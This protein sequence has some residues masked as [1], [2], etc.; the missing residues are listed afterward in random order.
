MK[1]DKIG[2][3]PDDKALA[4]LRRISEIVKEYTTKKNALEAEVRAFMD[5]VGH[6]KSL[7]AIGHTTSHC[8]SVFDREP[9]VTVDHL[10][11]CLL[12]SAWRHVYDGLNIA[13]IATAKDK[14][15]LDIFLSNPCEFT[16][17]NIREK[18][19]DYLLDT[20]QHVLRGLAECFSSL[21]AVYRSH[22]R[23]KIGVEG[24]PKRMIVQYAFDS[25]GWARYGGDQVKD[26]I[27][28]VQSLRGEPRFGY[29]EFDVLSRE[30]KRHG[31][32]DWPGG[33]LKAFK[34]GNAHIVFNKDTLK[35]VNLAL[36]EYYGDVIAD[37]PEDKPAKKRESREVSADLAYYPTPAPVAETIVDL[38]RPKSGDVILE[39]SCGDGRLMDAVASFCRE[40]KIENVKMMGVEFDA[41]RADEAKRKGY[42]VHVANFLEMPETPNFSLIIMNPPFCGRHYL[43]HIRSAIAMLKPGGRLFS[44]LP[45]SAWYDDHGLP[46]EKYD[47]DRPHWGRDIW[48]DLPI[49]S[50][51][52]SGTNIC[53]GIWKFRKDDIQ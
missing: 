22:D 23:M 40:Q 27:N 51:R 15:Q 30:A 21:D 6:V 33:T 3:G 50:F 53:T 5:H 12:G 18:F 19:G 7:V 25:W 16:I 24:M 35:E 17:E 2:N 29:V 28:A 11:R 46:G 45:A 4:P 37:C 42:S 31:E 44:I 49:G 1:Q 38:A 43:K 39:P 32:C 34:N 36:A 8:L 20:R 47:P 41:G 13:D 9:R 52:S 10:H 48:T 14:G 26:V